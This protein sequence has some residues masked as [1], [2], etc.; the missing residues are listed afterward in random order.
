MS[1]GFSFQMVIETAAA[2]TVAA[3]LSE[4]AQN[5]APSIQNIGVILCGGNVDLDALPWMNNNAP[6]WS[7]TILKRCTFAVGLKRW[8]VF[9]VVVCFCFLTCVRKFVISVIGLVWW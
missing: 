6:Q 3:V 2:T 1:F 5:L 4:H 9:I 7:E 8:S